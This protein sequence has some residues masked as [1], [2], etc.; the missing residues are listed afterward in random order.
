LAVASVVGLGGHRQAAAQ[1]NPLV[2]PVPVP[3]PVLAQVLALS[4]SR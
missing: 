4:I 1:G 3:V 2:V